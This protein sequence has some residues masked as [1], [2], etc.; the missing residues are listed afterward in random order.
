PGWPRPAAALPPP[1]RARG[2]ARGRSASVATT[3]PAWR[4]RHSARRVGRNSGRAPSS[5]LEVGVPGL[6]AALVLHVDQS[7]P[8]IILDRA[9]GVL[10]AGD[11]RAVDVV[12]D[13]A[14]L[15]AQLLGDAVA[16][17]VDQR[18]TWR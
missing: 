4:A 7:A 13:V 15:E 9:G 17:A 16:R 11:R 5:N 14:G 18:A 10:G 6:A 3:A 8:R 12:D 2:A 1:A